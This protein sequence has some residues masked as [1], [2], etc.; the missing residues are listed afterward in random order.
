MIASKQGLG[1][2]TGKEY[3]KMKLMFGLRGIV[4]G[5]PLMGDAG[6]VAVDESTIR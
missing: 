4:V 1:L 5:I 3:N 6:Y 2:E